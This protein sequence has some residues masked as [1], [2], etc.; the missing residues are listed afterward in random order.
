MNSQT[1]TKIKGRGRTVGSFSYVTLPGDQ[2]AKYPNVVVSRKWAEA[3]GIGSGVVAKNSI[4]T[5]KSV[6]IPASETQTPE[7]SVIAED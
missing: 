4:E 1:K 6:S 7:V 3:V 5:L 2:L